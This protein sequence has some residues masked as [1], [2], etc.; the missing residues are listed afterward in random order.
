[1]PL[2]GHARYTAVKRGISFNFALGFRTA[3]PFY[4]A[5]CTIT[6]S[7]G[8]DEGYSLGGSVSGMREWIGDREYGQISSAE[9]TLKNKT[10]EASH[11]FERHDV[12]D[13]RYNMLGMIA[14]QQGEECRT[15]PDQL[16]FN[17]MARGHQQQCWDGQFF[18]STNHLW[19]DS[20]VQSNIV[21]Y[22]VA[23]VNAVTTSEFKKAYHAA[24]IRMMTFK[25]D[26]GQPWIRP[27]V[28][29]LEN[30]RITVPTDLLELAFDTFEP[31]MKVST[32][33]TSF[34]AIDNVSIATP[35]IDNIPYL[36]PDFD[37]GSS[38]TSFYVHY[39]G[40]RIKPF[41]FQRRSQLQQQTKGADD[42]EFKDIKHLAEAR[43]NLGF[44]GW[45]YS[46][47]VNLVP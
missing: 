33:G 15:H 11:K 8:A 26:N 18:Y 39:L 2:V 7:Q 46:I 44:L 41:V 28:R 23:N 22:T 20:G 16:L 45:M 40:E 43:Y 9:F 34:A 10:W 4:P 5:V 21:D 17:L 25:R 1:M 32:E 14:Q 36:S 35:M 6:N 19:N 27:T 37:S 13:D 47:K 29:S 42:I 3:Q 31:A 24:L 12:D 38:S 30:V